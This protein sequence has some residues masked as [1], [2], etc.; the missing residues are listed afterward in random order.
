MGYLFRILTFKRKNMKNKLHILLILVSILFGQFSFAQDEK[1]EDIY[2]LTFPFP[3]GKWVSQFTWRII[4]PSAVSFADLGSCE[5]V[6]PD[7][8]RINTQI[9]FTFEEEF[10]LI[11]RCDHLLKVPYKRN[12]DNHSFEFDVNNEHF[13]FT[14]YYNRKEMIL[15]DQ[16]KMVLVFTKSE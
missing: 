13:S 2:Y 4:D 11:Q 12:E 1:E 10:I 9:S 3:S 16:D 7:N 15:V 5:R 8:Q 6:D 14:T